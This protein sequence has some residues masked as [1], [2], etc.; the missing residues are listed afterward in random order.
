M[1]HQATGRFVGCLDRNSA[2]R[3]SHDLDK[4]GVCIFCDETPKAAA[5]KAQERSRDV[6]R[7]AA[8]ACGDSRWMRH[9]RKLAQEI[10][11][12]ATEAGESEHPLP[13]ASA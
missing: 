2:Y 6:D 9:T 8:M 13:E 1:K 7:R 5:K 11:D 10:E 12:L 4:D 3:E